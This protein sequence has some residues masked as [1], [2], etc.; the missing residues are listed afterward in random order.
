MK[1]TCDACSSKYS[2]ADEK[3]QGRKVKVR[4]KGCGSNILV[5]GTQLQPPAEASEQGPSSADSAVESD[6][7][8]K[9]WSV[10]I[11]DD[12]SRDMNT[13]ELVQAWAAKLVDSDAY[14]WK[15]GMGDWKPILEV[16]ELKQLLSDALPIEEKKVLASSASDDKIEDLFG[17]VNLAGNGTDVDAN[18]TKSASAQAKTGVRNESSVLFSLDS[19]NEGL[20]TEKTEAADVFGTSLTGGGMLGS[21]ADL[22]TAPASEPASVP[23][24]ARSAPG[25]TKKSSTGL[26]ASIIVAVALIGGASIF[27]FGGD[28]AND[29]KVNAAANE[30]RQMAQAEAAT[31]LAKRQKEMDAEFARIK[32]E[33]EKLEKA[34]QEARSEATAKGEDA[35]AAEAKIKAEIEAKKQ[36][37]AAAKKKA[38]TTTSTKKP[39]TTPKK[40]TT[41]VKASTSKPK[42]KPSEPASSGPGF[43]KSAAVSALGAA[44]ANAAACKKPGGPVGKGKMTVTFSTSGRAIGAKITG[45]PFGGTP[46]GGCVVQTFRRARVPKFSGKPVT[47]TKS[48]RIN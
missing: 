20:P 6:P 38:Q 42:P 19:L 41:P 2:I 35:G 33:R 18:A 40:T 17:G 45:G 22:L 25:T 14:V 28:I 10:N 11:S 15:D 32:A 47:V 30:A 3:V 46:V 44:A 26:I 1:I 29:A 8:K 31:E 7:N 24:G 37:E 4:C 13:E 34:L 36:E 43:N 21:N 48:F 23:A 9:E 5:D 16:P 12:E 39:Q 27:A